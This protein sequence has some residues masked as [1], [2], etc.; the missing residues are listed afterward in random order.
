M[1]LKNVIKA[2]WVYLATVFISFC[3]ACLGASIITKAAIAVIIISSIVYLAI[4]LR[5]WRCPS[6]GE[7]LG[8]DVPRCCPN[9]GEKLDLSK[10]GGKS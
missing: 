1:K 2:R 4:Q 9:C 3:L 6:C 8:R 7:F 5:Y 10:K